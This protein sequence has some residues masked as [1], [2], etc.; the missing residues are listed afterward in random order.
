M[1]RYQILRQNGGITQV[2]DRGDW[3]SLPLYPSKGILEMTSSTAYE[4]IRRLKSKYKP[5]RIVGRP[6]LKTL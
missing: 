5:S 1:N 2:Y 4:L 3:Q 6:Y